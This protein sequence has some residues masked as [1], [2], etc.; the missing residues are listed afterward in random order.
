MGKLS[1]WGDKVVKHF[2]Y[3]CQSC[4]G[5]LET[6]KASVLPNCTVIQSDEY[7]FAVHVDICTC[8]CLSLCIVH[9]YTHI[10]LLFCNFTVYTRLSGCLFFIMYA[11]NTIGQLE[12][13]A[14]ALQVIILTWKMEQSS[15][16]SV[17]MMLTLQLSRR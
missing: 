4:N 10:C 11:M 12:N 17:R 15:H 7:R 8:M 9:V 13:V 3:C 1:M 16:T 2:W 14:M 6:L 5:D